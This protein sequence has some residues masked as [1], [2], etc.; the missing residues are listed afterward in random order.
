MVLDASTLNLTSAPRISTSLEEHLLNR[1]P[2]WRRL[3]R[4]V[5]PGFSLLQ[6]VWMFPR[7]DFVAAVFRYCAQWQR[8]LSSVILSSTHPFSNRLML[9]WA[10]QDALTTGAHCACA[11]TP[12]AKSETLGHVSLHCQH[13]RAWR[14]VRNAKL[15]HLSIYKLIGSSCTKMLVIGVGS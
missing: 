15:T 6:S 9:T 11:G 13:H 4:R 14:E 5:M 12:L 1:L 3:L 2:A 8:A 10:M 7:P